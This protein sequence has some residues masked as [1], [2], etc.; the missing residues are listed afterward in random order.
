MLFKPSVDR[1][2]ELRREW[3]AEHSGIFTMQIRRA[4]LLNRRIRR[5]HRE[6]AGARPNPYDDHATH[7]L[8]SRG[9][10]TVEAKLE[11][12]IVVL[13]ALAAPLGWAV[14]RFLYQRIETLIPDRLRS[15]PVPA[16]LI[17]AAVLGAL[18]TVLY[19]PG[20]S[21]SSAILAPWLMAQIPA[22][23]L[24][25]GIY[26]IL[27]G[28]L[29]IDGSTEWWP[30][31]PPPP[32]VDLPAQLLPDDLT[33]PSL[34][35][36]ETVAEPIELTPLGAGPTRSLPRSSALLLTALVLNVLGVIWTT[37]AVGVGVKTTVSEVLTPSSTIGL[38]YR[39]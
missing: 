11:L 21:L 12:T 1:Y 2:D 39:G 37:A 17:A 3:I 16:L 25:A 9:A 13:A 30:L 18:T 32:S 29:A 6:T 33:A 20:P 23:A 24:T 8:L 34:F 15:Y 27:N 35:D 36:T 22:T 38:T 28:W 26:G 10:K 4:E 19:N 31:T 14:G 7:P 5:R